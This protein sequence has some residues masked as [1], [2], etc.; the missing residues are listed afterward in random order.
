MS[1]WTKIR[2]RT[3]RHVHRSNLARL[4]W[5]SAGRHRRRFRRGLIAGGVIVLLAAAAAAWFLFFRGNGGSPAPQESPQPACASAR[6]PGHLGT[7]AWIAG[8][9][10]QVR[11]LD[12]CSQTTLVSAS[13]EAPVRFSPDGAWIAFGKGEVVASRGGAVSDWRMSSW[14]WARSGHEL[15]GVTIPDKPARSGRVFVGEPGGQKPVAIVG[16]A[17]GAAIDPRG[18]YVAVGIKNKVELFTVEGG[19]G[20]VLFSGPSKSAVKIQGWSPDGRWVVFW[21]LAKGRTSGL[22]D[23]APITGAGYHNVFDPVPAFDDLATWC[24]DTIVI[25]GGGGRQMSEGQQLLVSSAPDWRTHNLAGDFTKSWLWPNCS[26]NRKWIAVTVTPNHTERPPGEGHR[27]IELISVDGKTRQRL[28]LGA[29]VFEVPRWSA[30]GRTLLIV[31]RRQAPKSPGNVWVVQINPKT[32]KAT[33]IVKNV[34]TLGTAAVPLGHTEWTAIS[35]WNR[36]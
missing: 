30:D 16:G 35:D 24:G 6:L 8:G 23:V 28:A 33:K 1:R 17:S 29:G 20:K 21:D 7:I 32:G 13:A 26:P 12:T 18:R 2:P 5:G 19:G 36:G 25:S 31:Q 22:L 27:A 9:K 10:L 14:R 15:V 34:A 3:G 4:E 11:N